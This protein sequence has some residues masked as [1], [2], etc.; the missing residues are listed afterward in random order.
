MSFTQRH[1]TRQSLRTGSLV[2]KQNFEILKQVQDDNATKKIIVLFVQS[3]RFIFFYNVILR[4][5]G[6]SMNKITLTQEEC[7]DITEAVLH[8]M[9]LSD[10]VFDYCEYNY[11]SEKIPCVSYPMELIKTKCREILEII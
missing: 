1:Q 6:N 9:N 5:K 2:L 7:S 11:N 10:L 3:I 4:N 8:I